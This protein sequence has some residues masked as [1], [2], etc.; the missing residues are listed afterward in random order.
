MFKLKKR[1]LKPEKEPEL[2]N[3]LENYT[4][5]DPPGHGLCH[6]L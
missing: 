5:F 3:V 6:D 1:P 2:Y 4:D